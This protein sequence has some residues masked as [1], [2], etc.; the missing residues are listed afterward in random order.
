MQNALLD[1]S[2][3]TDYIEV[4]K[5][6]FENLYYYVWN[7]NTFQIPQGE[8][9]PTAAI[10]TQAALGP[11]LFANRFCGRVINVI[12]ATGTIAAVTICCK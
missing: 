10:V 6:Q 11:A 5:S 1:S 2:C 4:K 7:W 9:G 12:S 3:Q 8:L